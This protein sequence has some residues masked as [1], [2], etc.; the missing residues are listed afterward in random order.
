MGIIKEG[1]SYFTSP[2]LPTNF[3]A[4]EKEDMET[5]KP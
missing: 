2:S 3:G 5:S 4:L 1:F